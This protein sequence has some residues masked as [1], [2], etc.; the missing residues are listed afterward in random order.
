VTS[1]MGTNQR[2]HRLLDLDLDVGQVAAGW[3]FE[4][5]NRALEY[6]G[7]LHPTKSSPVSIT[8]NVTARITRTAQNFELTEA[9]HRDINTLADH[10]RITMVLEDGT[11]WPCGVFLFDDEHEH[12][13]SQGSTWPME[14]SDFTAE[15]DDALPRSISV[16]PGGQVRPVLVQLLEEALIFVHDIAPSTYATGQALNFPVGTSRLEVINQLATYMGMLP[17]YFD[18]AGTAVVR[19]LPQVRGSGGQSL[20]TLH[21]NVDR[22]RIIP[23][24]SVINRNTVKAPNAYLVTGNGGGS[25]PVQAISYVDPNAEISKENRGRTI[26]KP[27]QDQGIATAE[28]AQ[29]RAD[30]LA[31]TDIRQFATASFT[32]VPDPRH[33]TYDVIDFL[34]EVWLEVAWTMACT[35][36]GDHTHQIAKTLDSNPA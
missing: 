32:S 6:Q 26:T 28:Q 8:N 2:P 29:A 21:Y 16:E 15:L 20:A 13:H 5:V 10:V 19:P 14:L 36:G 24:S 12:L 33:D 7:E 17:V 25:V 22:S 18:N 30:A 11:R 3:R 27:V 4:L 35:P 34:D 9:E 1:A 23:D 31:Q